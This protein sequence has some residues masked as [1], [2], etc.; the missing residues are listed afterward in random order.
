MNGLN[1]FF[2]G[3]WP[4]YKQDNALQ[5][6]HKQELTKSI[7]SCLVKQ[8]GIIPLRPLRRPLIPVYGHLVGHYPLHKIA[9]N[10]H[11]W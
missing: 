4:W 7:N 5:G 2:F 10:L 8:K 3:K 6:V 11:K 1:F 9:T